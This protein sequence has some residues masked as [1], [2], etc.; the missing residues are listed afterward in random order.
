MPLDI[1]FEILC[2]LEPRDLLNL[3]RTTKPFRRFL[4]SRRSAS[5]W[6]AARANVGDLPDCPPHLSEPQYAN[7]LFFP[8]CNSCLKPNVRHV[9]W[10]FSARYCPPC[11]RKYTIKWG[12]LRCDLE[13]SW[14]YFSPHDDIF[15]TMYLHGWRTFH[16]PELD[17]LKRP[18]QALR[19]E[20][21][22]VRLC[23]VPGPVRVGLHD[24]AIERK[25]QVIAIAEHA[26]LCREWDARR[27]TE[28]LQGLHL[29][30]RQR[31][32][33]IVSKLRELGF[34]EVLNDIAAQDYAPLSTH[35]HV[36]KAKPLT[37]RAWASIQDDLVE[38][39]Q[40]L[41]TTA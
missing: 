8:Y 23:H 40:G 26:A 16:C 2:Y 12:Q 1:L 22:R 7:L 35:S 38:F 4:M 10:E 20:E 30:R 14:A 19:R 36:R 25:Q 6:K 29:I 34:G 15:T 5:T 11:T 31:L 3:A 37:D 9:L 13:Y 17:T 41:Q 18:C 39:V 28:R 24:W 33:A 27:V 32:D 21:E